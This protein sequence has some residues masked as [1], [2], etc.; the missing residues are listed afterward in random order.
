MSKVKID[1][2]LCRLFFQLVE[3]L[4]EVRSH[5][6]AMVSLRARKPVKYDSFVGLEN[7]DLSDDGKGNPADDDDSSASEEF[8]G[9]E[10]QTK[11]KR[12]KGKGRK[13]SQHKRYNP[14]E[15]DESSDDAFQHEAVSEESDSDD[16]N[17]GDETPGPSSKRSRGAAKTTKR[18]RADRGGYAS[19]EPL[20]IE[21]DEDVKP[22]LD[23]LVAAAGKGV[24]RRALQGGGDDG[25]GETIDVGENVRTYKIRFPRL[26]GGKTEMLA[27]T[28]PL[29][30]LG[31][32]SLALEPDL[33]KVSST[34]VNSLP[35]DPDSLRSQ[36]RAIWRKHSETIPLE[37]PWQ[38]WE[39]EPWFPECYPSQNAAS[40]SRRMIVKVE[41]GEEV[42]WPRSRWEVDVGVGDSGSYKKDEIKILS[43]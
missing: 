23:E 41:P 35:L 7:L 15:E 42:S 8:A 3:L 20:Y 24:R 13:T 37:I 4:K 14:D 30:S 21:E 22:A 9:D 12:S 16:G 5:S 18:K 43:K 38:F 11:S 39:G 32:T 10:P 25:Y 17:E 2:K 29:H 31:V 6:Q 28:Y 33:G 26:G 27:S 19:D 1:Y 36:R 40:Q 34:Q